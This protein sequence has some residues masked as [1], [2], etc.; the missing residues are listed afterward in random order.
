M[1]ALHT[2]TSEVSSQPR[3]TPY[4]LHTLHSIKC[5]HNNLLKNPAAAK[6]WTTYGTPQLP[7]N[8]FSLFS[9]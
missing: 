5:Y 9:S 2:R 3:K 6:W 4:V 8:F 7:T 1:P